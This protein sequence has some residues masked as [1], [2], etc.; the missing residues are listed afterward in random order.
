MNRRSFLKTVAAAAVV[1]VASISP[2]F[3]VNRRNMWSPDATSEE[4]LVRCNRILAA[5]PDDV[6]ALIHRGQ[7]PA[8]YTDPKQA[9]ADHSRAISLEPT[10]PCCW[11]IRGVCFDVITD[12]QHAIGLL[13]KGDEICGKALCSEQPDLYCW[14]GTEDGEL[15]FMANR[16]LGSASEGQGHMNEALAAFEWAWSFQVI[17]QADLERWSES[18][19]QVGRWCEAV[20]GY[21]SLIEIEPKAEY[22]LRLEECLRWM[23]VP[24]QEWWV[25]CSGLESKP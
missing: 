20:I 10:N 12:L 7:V 23:R 11:Y 21:R 14:T 8:I 1:P 15:F 5:N 16:E 24:R 22:R 13:S 4:T 17:T 2:A 6:L 3:T 25:K 9:W 19:M 18:D